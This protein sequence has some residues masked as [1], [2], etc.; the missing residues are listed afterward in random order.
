M[1]WLKFTHLA[2]LTVWV[3]GL[4]YL[5][6]ILAQYRWAI[7]QQESQRVRMASRFVFL[8]ITSPAAIVAIASGTALLF[9]SDVRS[10]WMFAK[11]GGVGILAYCH[12]RYGSLLT[13]LSEALP[14]VS[15]FKIRL[16]GGSAALAVI[17]IMCIVLIKPDLQFELLPDWL[18]EP[19]GIV[20]LSPH[21][22]HSE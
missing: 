21:P 17:Y 8:V 7:D 18:N 5:P 10:A 14:K 1:L 22:D 9:I 19:V 16:L 6:A 2:A 20:R 12:Y 11:L 13:H 15:S 3:A 4:L